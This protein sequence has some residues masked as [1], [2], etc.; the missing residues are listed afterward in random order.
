MTATRK[1][2]IIKMV[3]EKN[4][5]QQQIKKALSDGTKTVPEIA[6]LTGLP[7]QTVLWHLTALV[8]YGKAAQAEQ[9]GDYMTYRTIE[10]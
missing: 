6:T 7:S 10:G 5:I 2:E 1:A 3:Q 8:K 9:D 4:D